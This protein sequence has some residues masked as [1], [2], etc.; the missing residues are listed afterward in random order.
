ML[1][2]ELASV[3]LIKEEFRSS[4][5]IVLTSGEFGELHLYVIELEIFMQQIAHKKYI[6]ADCRILSYFS[7]ASR[8]LSMLF[9]DY[10][11]VFHLE[12]DNQNKAN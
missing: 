5:F 11:L 6:L 10:I 1:S 2:C 4:K 7:F 9:L 12:T 8:L 3:A